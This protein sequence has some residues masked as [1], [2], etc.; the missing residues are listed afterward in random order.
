MANW[1]LKLFTGFL[2]VNFVSC[3]HYTREHLKVAPGGGEA[4]AR[5]PA[6]GL[7]HGGR[8][9]C[10]FSHGGT[11]LNTRRMFR[12]HSPGAMLP[13]Q[14]EPASFWGKYQFLSFWVTSSGSKNLHRKGANGPPGCFWQRRTRWRTCIGTFWRA[15]TSGEPGAG[16]AFRVF[17]SVDLTSLGSHRKPK[18]H[19]PF[20]GNHL[21]DKAR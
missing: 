21:A 6:V 4:H 7:S 14:K 10:R 11:P 8:K 12:V 15:C 5:L 2:F 17:R 9:K 1:V 20:S 19:P 3:L 18:G 16:W 13:T